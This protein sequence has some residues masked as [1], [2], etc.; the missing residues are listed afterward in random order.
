MPVGLNA[1]EVQGAMYRTVHRQPLLPYRLVLAAQ[2]KV[3]IVPGTCQ[4]RPVEATDC[5][6][7][8]DANPLTSFSHLLFSV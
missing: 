5:A 6:S 3:H 2:Q 7:A 4:Q 1:I 8:N